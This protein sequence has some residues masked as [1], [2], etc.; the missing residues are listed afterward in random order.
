[1][2]RVLK[3]LTY[4]LGKDLDVS[5]LGYGA[6]RLTGEGVW[7]E[8]ANK[9]SALKLL[10]KAV[11]AGVNF[12]DTADAYGPHTNEVLIADALYP[13]KP[14]LVIATKGG[15]VRTGPGQWPVNGKPEHIREA[16][17]GSLNRL[18]VKRIDLWQLH[19]FDPK[20]PVEETLSPVVDAVKAG[21]IKH[22][23]LS[24]VSIADIMRAEK[25]LPIVS[26]QNMYNLGERTWDEVVDYTAKRN[27]AFI[28]WYPL[29]SDP[30]QLSGKLEII[31]ARH[32]ATPAQIALAW[33]LHRS[34]NIIVIPGTKSIDHLL[35]N[36]AAAK[37]NLSERDFQELSG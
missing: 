33:L 2:E 37:I 11:E 23:G 4:S 32:K 30:G 29:A 22:V 12:I 14:G 16:I 34:P 1:M 7:G 20:V 8:V 9:A 5:R 35:E 18:R 36:I 17:E 24:E 31:A 27:I 19:R 6:M 10:K 28:P 3:T 13:Y 15:L 25:I 26:V 21:K